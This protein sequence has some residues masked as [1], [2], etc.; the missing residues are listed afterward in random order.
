MLEAG[1]SCLEFRILK[2]VMNEIPFFRSK[3]AELGRIGSLECEMS[4][5]L[6]KS[7]GEWLKNES[8]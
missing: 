3:V 4:N 5:K 1:V 6:E 7:R 2:L 8:K